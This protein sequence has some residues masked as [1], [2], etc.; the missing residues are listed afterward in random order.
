M[1]IAVTGANGFV[2]R[3]L[4][5]ELR[6]AGHDVL[7]GGTDR[8]DVTDPEGLAAWLRSVAPGAVVH[9]A[10]IAFGPEAARDPGRAFAVTVGG[11]VA[12]LEA[13]RTIGPPPWV[14]VPSSGEVYG[15]PGEWSLPLTEAAPIRPGGPYALS[16]VAQES[17]A[18][19]LGARTGVPV[20]VTRAFNHTG[21]G[22]RIDF[23]VPALA[24]RVHEFA[25]GDAP[26]IRVGNLDVARDFL[27]V[28]DVARA[29]RLLVE[30]AGEGRIAPSTIVNVASGK[31][32][33]VRWILEEL[34]RLASVD[35]A[36]EV[37]RALVRPGEPVDIRGDASRLRELVGWRPEIP[38]AQTL[39]EVLARIGERADDVASPPAVNRA[40]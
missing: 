20:I 29:Y 8:P 27:D 1:R 18:L 22:Q 31:S 39:K 19:A 16:K 23:V 12:V 26:A 36:L 25:R 6:T 34:C 37:D 3:W 40:R 21:P 15:R 17:V 9:L 5:A 38:F 2:G 11:T 4:E 13:A 28:R 35:P 32:V 7:D 33:A 30:A 24:H 10:A 14:L